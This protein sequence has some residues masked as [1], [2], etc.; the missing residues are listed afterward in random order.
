MGEILRI[1]Y[2]YRQQD[3]EDYVPVRQKSVSSKK[4]EALQK[5]I[6]PWEQE[7]KDAAVE[8]KPIIKKKKGYWKKYEIDTIEKDDEY[9]NGRKIAG[10]HCCN[11]PDSGILNREDKS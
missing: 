7:K 11:Q 9:G 3:V 5:G 8:E 6:M 4:V 1:L 2:Q 10:M